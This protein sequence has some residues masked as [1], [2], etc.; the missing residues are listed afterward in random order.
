[1]GIEKLY[2]DFFLFAILCTILSSLCVMKG[3]ISTHLVAL[4]LKNTDLEIAWR[5][6]KNSVNNSVP[7]CLLKIIKEKLFKSQTEGKGSSGVVQQS[8]ISFCWFL[9]LRVTSQCLRCQAAPVDINEEST[10]EWLA[11]LILKMHDLIPSLNVGCFD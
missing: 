1:M 9:S 4:P 10:A 5:V 2:F 8:L 6:K 3:A 11:F 7:K